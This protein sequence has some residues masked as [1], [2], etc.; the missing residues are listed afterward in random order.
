MRHSAFIALTMSMA[1]AAAS[2]AAPLPKAQPTPG[3]IAI[4]DIPIATTK[5]PEL[6]YR[7]RP[8]MVVEDGDKWRAIVG[9]P[10]DTKPGTHYVENANA[11]KKRVSFT[12]KKKHYPEQWLTIKNKRKVNPNTQDMKRIT[13]ERKRKQQAKAHW[14]PDLNT[15]NLRFILPVKGRESSQ[16]GLKRYFN[17]QA[18]R[19]HSG[20]DIAAATGT[21]IVAPANGVV[22]EKG[23]FFFSG[24]VVYLDHGQGLISLYAHMS[25]INVNVGDRIK[26]G[27]KIGEVGATG[28][29]TGPHLHWSV[30]LNN[31]WIDPKLLLVTP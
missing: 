28:R 30:A 4:I 27:E 3:G 20:L 22:I 10:L 5:Q 31:T 15:M 19:P 9:I 1:S 7:K 24:N 14:S 13:T 23:N 21:T 17:K 11:A 26:R 25:Q 18:R 29:V 2:A 12:V 16:F 8:V 6:R